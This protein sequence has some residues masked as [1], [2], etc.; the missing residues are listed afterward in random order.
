DATAPEEDQLICVNYT[1]GTTGFAKG[2]MFTHRSAY[3]NAMG[4]MLEHGLTSRSVYLWT[5]P[6]FHCNGWCFSWAV[7]AAGARHGGLRP[8]GAGARA[9]QSLLHWGAA[10]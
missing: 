4:E 6:L 7:T 5:V 9:S 2:V 3:L 10:L 8:G 1:S